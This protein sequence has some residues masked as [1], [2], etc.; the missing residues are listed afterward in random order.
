MIWDDGSWECYSCGAWGAGTKE[1]A[2][3]WDCE[4]LIFREWI[5]DVATIL[6]EGM[7]VLH[8]ETKE[9]E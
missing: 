1:D 6:I 7:G 8:Q 4:V 9:S 2:H 3:F 5:G